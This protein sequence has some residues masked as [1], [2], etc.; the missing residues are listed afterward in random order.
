M[1]HFSLSFPA[2]TEQ[3]LLMPTRI[4]GLW[5]AILLLLTAA[6]PLVCRAESGVIEWPYDGLTLSIDCKRR[7]AVRFQYRVTRDTGHRPRRQSFSLDRD[8]PL[9][10]EQTSAD[11]YTADGPR[12]DR[13]HLV[14]AN[15]LDQLPKGI[16]S[17]P[18]RAHR[19]PGAVQRH[20]R[21]P[22]RP[23]AR[24]VLADPR[25]L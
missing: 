4:L 15:H 3:G 16:H 2:I 18:G 19:R 25:P 13:G 22:Q 21:C 8:F 24:H 23:S 12:Y 5:A 9:D 11:A 7:G 20:P 6:Q 10:C 14:P 1:Q 17:R